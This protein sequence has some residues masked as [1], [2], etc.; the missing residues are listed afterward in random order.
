MKL[1][2]LF[3]IM[4]VSLKIFGQN[5]HQPLYYLNSEQIVD[6]EK[7][8][9][10]PLRIDSM[11]VQKKSEFGEILMFTKNNEFSFYRLSD[12]LKKFTNIYGLTDSLIFNIDG[13]LIEDT[14]SI[15]IDDSFFIYVTIDKLNNFKYISKKY[16]S[17]TIV[18][19]DLEAKKQERVMNI[20]GDNDI[21]ENF[22]K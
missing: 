18:N 10:N 6:L 21:L 11:C 1:I 4:I 20:R 17:L 9:L 2:F 15:I 16:R 13:K 5:S 19:I 12:I 7:F 3:L 22:K 8:Y 14:T